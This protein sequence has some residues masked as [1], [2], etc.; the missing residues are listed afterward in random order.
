M[1]LF[2]TFGALGAPLPVIDPLGAV[3]PSA[4]YDAVLAALVGP[5]TIAVHDRRIEQERVDW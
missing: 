4:I 3:V 1:I 5:L 2:A